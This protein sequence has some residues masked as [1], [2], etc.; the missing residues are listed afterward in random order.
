MGTADSGL[1]LKEYETFCIAGEPGI[2]KKPLMD[3]IYVWTY[4]MTDM[5]NQ[6]AVSDMV[7]Y[8]I[9]GGIAESE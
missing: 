7:L 2:E 1:A 8:E 9:E 4:D 6:Y 5:W 3:G